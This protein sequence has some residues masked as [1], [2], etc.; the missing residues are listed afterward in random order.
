MTILA[1][2]LQPAFLRVPVSWLLPGVPLWEA[3]PLILLLPSWPPPKGRLKQQP[4]YCHLSVLQVTNLHRTQ[5]SDSS[6]L[7]GGDQGHTMAFSCAWSRLDSP[8]WL[9]HTSNAWA[10]MAGRLDTAEP[11][12]LSA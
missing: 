8:R 11:H 9:T 5:L 12:S 3:V 4:S 10:G 2:T 6:A 7:H 1:L